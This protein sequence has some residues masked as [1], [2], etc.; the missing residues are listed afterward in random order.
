[1]D[2]QRLGAAGDHGLRLVVALASR[3]HLRLAH[4][5]A[6]LGEKLVRRR[7]GV[8]ERLD[9]LQRSSTARASSMSRP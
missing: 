3:P 1:M 8:L 9:P 4:E 5:Q 7:A 2:V 6:Q